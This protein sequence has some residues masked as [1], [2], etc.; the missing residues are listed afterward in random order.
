[1]NVFQGLAEAP[2]IDD[3][4][5]GDLS[6]VLVAGNRG[7]LHSGSAVLYRGVRI[8]SILSTALAEDATGVIADVLIR[9]RYAPLVRENSRF[10]Q[11]GAF[12]VEI[13]LSGG[14]ARLD[15]LETLLVGG[16]SL[17][18]PTRFGE[19]VETGH[20]FAVDAEEDDDWLEWR[21]EI[22]IP[23]AD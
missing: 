18:T 21:P 22:E 17:V 5:P 20:V 14:R 10:F 4:A 19:Q 23:P 15:S 16:V 11:T 2:I 6:L 1:M 3:I 7:S 9:A 8:G 13:G 12:D